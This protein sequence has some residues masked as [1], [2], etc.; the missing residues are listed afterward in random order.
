M[1]DA[2][3]ALPHDEFE[4][5]LT[6]DSELGDLFQYL[7]GKRRKSREALHLMRLGLMYL[8]GGL[9]ATASQA[10]AG[11]SVVP[12]KSRSHRAGAA[13]PLSQRKDRK[14]E[15]AG[16]TGLDVLAGL[17]PEFFAGPPA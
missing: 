16:P 5:R 10:V 11:A 8:N 9:A 2:T 15:E 7:G 4:I 1:A 12:A 14:A 6:I 13:S 17:P 3:E